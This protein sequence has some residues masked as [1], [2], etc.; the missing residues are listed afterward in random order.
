MTQKK[1]S[2]TWMKD[3]AKPTM[4][5]ILGSPQGILH[6]VTADGEFTYQQMMRLKM[7]TYMS[8]VN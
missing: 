2:T 3:Q 7:D 1:K 5:I 6:N 8:R 4:R